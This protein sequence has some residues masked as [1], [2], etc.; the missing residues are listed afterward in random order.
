METNEDEGYLVVN[1]LM[2]RERFIASFENAFAAVL[3]NSNVNYRQNAL[4]Y[5]ELLI[6]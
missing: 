1:H 3:S 6:K 4:K 5:F 2:F